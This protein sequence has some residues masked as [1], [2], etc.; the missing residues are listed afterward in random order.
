MTEKQLPHAWEPKAMN[1]TAYEI[2]DLSSIEF[3]ILGACAFGTVH[4]DLML[5][6]ALGFHEEEAPEGLA[7][8][9]MEC[10]PITA[11]L[12]PLCAWQFAMTLPETCH[13]VENWRDIVAECVA[14]KG[15]THPQDTDK[16]RAFL[17]TI[18]GVP[19]GLLH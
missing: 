8:V 18:A 12:S 19:E 15:G 7:M 11:I 13:S 5:G 6:A 10:G 4:R 16:G 2:S 14:L 9:V 3:A 1:I 17:S